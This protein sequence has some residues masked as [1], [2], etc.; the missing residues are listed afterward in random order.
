MID[1]LSHFYA[2]ENSNVHRAA[3]ALAARSTDAFE[4]AREKVRRFLNAPSDDSIVWVRGTTEA[5]NLVAKAWGRRNVNEGDEVVVTDLEHHSN[6]VPWQMLCDEKAP[7]SASPRWTTAATSCSTSMSA[8]Q[9]EDA[10]RRLHPCLQRARHRH[11]RARHDRDGASPRR[12][13]AGRR[14]AGRCHMP[15]DVQALGA[16]FYVCPATRCSARPASACSTASPR[17]WKRCRKRDKD[18]FWAEAVAAYRDGEPWWLADAGLLE[19]AAEEQAARYAPDEWGEVIAAYVEHKDV[20]SVSEVLGEA[21]SMDKRNGTDRPQI[22]AGQCLTHIGWDRRRAKVAD[23][24]GRRPYR[25]HRPAAK[26]S[27]S[28]AHDEDWDG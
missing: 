1:R 16:D 2:R 3:H 7:R 18:Q 17:S 9:S 8:T 26:P 4:A 11:A 21:L 22:R 10:H 27:N 12:A 13:C 20:T 5:I 25:Y 14:R 28:L 6:I 19:A 15:V 23:G 24:T